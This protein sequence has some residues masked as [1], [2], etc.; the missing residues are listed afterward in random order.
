MPLISTPRVRIPC[1]EVDRVATSALTSP[2]VPFKRRSSQNQDRGEHCIIP[3][4]LGF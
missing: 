4:L 1:G 2:E 3:V